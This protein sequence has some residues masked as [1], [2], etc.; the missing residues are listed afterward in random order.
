MEDSSGHFIN[1]AS[2][3]DLGNVS[4]PKTYEEATASRFVAKWREAMT[5]EIKALI[6]NKTWKEVDRCDVPHGKSIT[7][8]RWVF[9]LKF[10]RDGTI[11]RF[12]AR[13]VACGYSQIFGQDFYHTFAATM[14]ATSLRLFFAIAAGRKMRVHQ[15]D[16][17]NAFTQADIDAEIYVEA[18]K[19]YESK[20]RDGKNRVLKLQKALYGTKQAARLWQETLVAKLKAM[21]FTQSPNDPCLFRYVGPH[22]ECLIAAYVDDLL[23]AVS[24]K[25]T[26]EWFQSQF[27]KT[28]ENPGGFYAKYLGPLHFFLGMAVDQHADYS[29]SVN[30]TK[31]IEKML[32][33]FVPS[34][35]MNAIKHS[36]PCVVEKFKELS[37]ATSDLEREEMKNLPYLQV[38]GSLLYVMCMTRPDVAFHVTTLCKFMHD[39]SRDC[40]DAA[41]ALLLYLGHTKDMVG[42]HYDG[43]S[44]APPGLGDSSHAESLTSGK[45]ARTMVENNHGLIAYSDASWRSKAG[46]YSS[47]GY[48]I[49]LFGGV[50]SFAS[51]YLKVVALSSAE[52]EYAAASQTCR[53]LTFVRKVCTDLGLEIQGRVCVAVDNTA[54]ISIIHNPGVTARNKHFDDATHYIRD[55]YAHNRIGPIHVTTDAQKADGFTKPLDAATWTWWR[56]AVIPTTHPKM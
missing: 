13:F 46:S 38:I 24:S 25:K 7:K 15:F 20:G 28:D 34:H 1:V 49:Y 4:I 55:E 12:K 27:I 51:K 22:G 37:T 18:P 19:G 30:Q 36:K 26:L 39:P 21:G 41:I 42:L 40:Y 32:N 9:D 6:L 11:E 10:L 35:D 44:A 50:V 56:G 29:I 31:Y 47:Y 54:A 3:V 17:S 53:E 52:A 5:K 45:A 14:R 16:V 33:K 23:C 43:N 2:N 48:V 8:S